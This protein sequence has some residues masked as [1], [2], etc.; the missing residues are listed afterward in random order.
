MAVPVWPSELPQR[1]LV[2]GY[3]EKSRDG[4]MFSRTSSGPG[5]LRRRY[6]SAVL[7]VTATIIVS[8]GQKSRLERF[9]DEETFGGSLPFTMPD[10]THDGLPLLSGGG[11]PLFGD[12][13][14]PILI[15]ANWLARFSEGGL[16]QYAPW[17]LQFM[18][19]FQ[20]DVLP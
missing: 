13:G 7:P 3:S 16:P 4:R 2:D 5:K 1:V 10:Q 19:S 14:L 6:S 8:Y 9:V 11:L 17:G 18:A 15:T 20:L 12:D